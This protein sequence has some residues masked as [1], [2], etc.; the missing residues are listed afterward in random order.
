[1]EDIRR[2]GSGYVDPTAHKAIKNVS[3]KEKEVAK[4][5]KTLQSVAHLAGYNIEGR[6]TL[7]D[8]KTSK[9]WR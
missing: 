8:N 1:M 3:E 2:N 9:V 4:V 5:I 6:I 7:I